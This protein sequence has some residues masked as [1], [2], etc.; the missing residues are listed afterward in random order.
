MRMT[1]VYVGSRQMFT[2]MNCTLEQ[3]QVHPVV[4]RVFDF[5]DAPLAYPHQQ[6]GQHFG[7]VVIVRPIG[8]LGV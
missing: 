2:R 4:D 6:S 1:G 5:L 3:A 8:V 7:M